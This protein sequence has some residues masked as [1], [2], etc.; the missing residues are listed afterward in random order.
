MYQKI[1]KVGYLKPSQRMNMMHMMMTLK[2]INKK[3]N[4]IFRLNRKN[5]KNRKKQKNRNL[6]KNMN[7]NKNCQRK[8]FFD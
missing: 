4:H 5:N 2:I 7:L 6:K 1:N 3:R 8:V